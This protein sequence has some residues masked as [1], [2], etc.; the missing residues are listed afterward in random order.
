MSDALSF[1]ER[2]VFSRSAVFGNLVRSE[3]MVEPKTVARI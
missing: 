2:L 1:D 3:R